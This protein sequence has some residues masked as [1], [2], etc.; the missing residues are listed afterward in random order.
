[1]SPVSAVESP[2]A[3]VDLP[4][5]AATNWAFVY[6]AGWWTVP[7]HDREAIDQRVRQVV[8]DRLGR[9]DDRASARREAREHLA[10]AAHGAAERDGQS[11]AVFSM[12]IAGVAITGTM[13]VFRVGRPGDENGALLPRLAGGTAGAEVTRQAL[14]DGWVIRAVRQS[15][16]PRSSPGGV[17]EPG[18]NAGTGEEPR[19]PEL[20]ADYWTE[21]RGLEH[22]LQI[23]FTTPFVPLRDAL[24]ELFDTIVLSLHP[25]I[26]G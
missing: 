18:G 11:L 6:P 20:R 24:L 21:R 4:E 15:E 23:S 2:D 17:A 10:A 16:V 13:A 9:R 5:G 12:Q 26:R 19:L 22:S 7:L 25:V 8:V 1:M 3:S 14:E